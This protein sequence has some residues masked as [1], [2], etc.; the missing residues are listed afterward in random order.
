MNK[1]FRPIP[2][3][4]VC[5]FID[6][7]VYLDKLKRKGFGISKKEQE[8]LGTTETHQWRNSVL[9]VIPL[10]LGLESVS[11]DYFSGLKQCFEFPETMG[12]VGG[13]PSS[14][15]YF[16]GVQDDSFILLDPHYVQSAVKDRKELIDKSST[17]HCKI[18]RRLELENMDTSLA[19]GYAV[20][21][22]GGHV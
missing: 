4:E 1:R 8:E 3:F 22:S 13:K 6:G 10:R 7:F 21:A 19:C 2:N 12:I 18:A 14:A 20:H 9:V 15:M 5:V 16:V 17:Y 11:S